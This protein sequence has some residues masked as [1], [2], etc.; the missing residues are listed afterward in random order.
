LDEKKIDCEKEVK[1]LGVTIDCQLK[2]NAHISNICKKAS[3]QLNVL[4]R[5]GKHLTNLG[6]LTIYFSFIMSNFNYCPIVWHFCGETNTKIF[7]KKIKKGPSDL[8]MKIIVVH[9]K[10]HLNTLDFFYSKFYKLQLPLFYGV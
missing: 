5:I 1:L 10:N 9:M 3:R 8:F 2:C 4:K 6:R 7:L